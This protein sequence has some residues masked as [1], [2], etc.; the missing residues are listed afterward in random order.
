LSRNK[1]ASLQNFNPVCEEVV[2]SV[3]LLNHPLFPIFE[4]GGLRVRLLVC[5]CE[6]EVLEGEGERTR[7]LS[8]Q[9]SRIDRG[10]S[11]TCY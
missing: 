4:T 8:R 2:T 9:H 5:V 11:W 6:P 3:A 1:L 7:R 10:L